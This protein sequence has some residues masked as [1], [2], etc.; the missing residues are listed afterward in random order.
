[1]VLVDYLLPS[2]LFNMLTPKT[3]AY[4]QAGVVF[5]RVIRTNGGTGTQVIE[6]ET[7][8]T[9][10]QAKQYLLDGW[11]PENPRV[12]FELLAAVIEDIKAG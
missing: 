3:N 11:N 1:M 8:T 7:A 10:P 5:T 6:K 4:V 12:V 2:L 9:L